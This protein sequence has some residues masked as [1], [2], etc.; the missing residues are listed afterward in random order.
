MSY[1][2]NAENVMRKK[3]YKGL[4][5]FDVCFLLVLLAVELIFAY[6][7]LLY[8]SLYDSEGNGFIDV[9]AGLPHYFQMDGTLP[10]AA[11]SLHSHYPAFC[12]S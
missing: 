11:E 1:E 3:S 4:I 12:F 10:L 6:Q 2:V 9:L 8:L 7:H 5:L